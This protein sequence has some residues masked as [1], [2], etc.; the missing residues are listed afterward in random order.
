M[1][2]R[3]LEIDRLTVQIGDLHPVRDVSLAIE[4]GQIF[5]IAGESGSGKSMTALAVMGLLPG[6]ADRAGAARLDGQDLFTLDEA[7]MCGVRGRRI[8]MIFQEPMT[9]LN[10]VRTIGAQVAE[11]L[12]I[13]QGLSR[14]E[15]E[16][17]AAAKLDRVG[18][19]AGRVGLD[20]Y[21][22]E[23]SGGQRQRVM[24][25]QAIALQPALLIAD[26][27]TTALD[28]TTQAGILDLMSGLVEEGDMSLMLITHDLAVLA[29]LSSAIAVMKDGRIV[30]SGATE[31][32]FR[33]HRH[34]YTGRL[35]AAS[36]H[37]PARPAARQAATTL[38]HVENLHVGYQSR[39][40]VLFGKG[41]MTDAVR[42]VS[43]AI[44]AGES[45][46]LVGESGC[47]KST[48]ARTILGLQAA[49]SG[50]VR[51]GD[52]AV[53]GG[54]MPARVRAGMQIVF[55]D[56]YGSFN[57]RHR[58]ARLVAEPF[59]LIEDAPVGTAREQAVA[60]ALEAVGMAASDAGKYIHEFSGGQRQ[61]IAIARALVI[62]PKLIILDEAVSALDVSIRAQILDLLAALR[63]SHGLTYLFISHDL[64]VVRSI[65][66]RVMVMKDGVIVEQ[67]PVEEV[68]ERPNHPYTRELVAARP[69]IPPE[70]TAR[71]NR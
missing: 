45:V 35:L 67:G 12:T 23:L 53:T 42:G 6:G 2:M 28:V 30:E 17:I 69:Q 70:W 27:P 31:T 22:H 66:D 59:H 62:R 33:S 19:A 7:A 10:P 5:G 41:A 3:R 55:Q 34:A 18:L 54:A 50:S 63:D 52:D 43:L 37:A 16:E 24:I 49:R 44:D 46:G 64:G 68:L 32:L 51:L 56:P 57:P 21:P 71:D 38:L 8:G 29:G 11:T 40:P 26:E 25:A 14:G 39:R 60:A 58:V 48:L 9:A 47:G 36:S 65:T 15:A 13:H 4:P 1:T 20:R 61:R